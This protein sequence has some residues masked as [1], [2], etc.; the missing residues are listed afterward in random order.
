MLITVDTGEIDQLKICLKYFKMSIH[1][2]SNGFLGLPNQVVSKNKVQIIPFGLEKTV[3]YNGGTKFGPRNIIKASHQVELFDEELKMLSYK[4]FN[5]E[6]L[7]IIKIKSKLKD[8]LLQL[9][10]IVDQSL[11]KNKLPIVL[12]GEHTITPAIIKSFA[13]KYSNLTIVQIDAH[14]DLRNN[15]L[16]L[17]F[18]HAT[19]MRRCLDYKNINIISFG[20]RNLSQEEYDYINKNKKR[21]KIFWAKDSHKW[22]M[23]KFKKLLKNKNVYVTFDLDGFDSSLMP[24]TGTP[25]PGGLFW[26]DAM[27]ILKTTFENSHVVGA[28]VS[29]LSPKKN[30][31]ACDFLAAKLVYKILSYKFAN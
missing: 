14:A 21:I 25:E 2:P 6:T 20:I 16:G 8:A 22:N 27:K 23:T 29:E 28:D 11:I 1:K 9:T 15:Y 17:N 31:F 4:K 12:G 30:L 10:K 19:A 7:K 18:S 13:N 5:I 24:A 26:N 3:T